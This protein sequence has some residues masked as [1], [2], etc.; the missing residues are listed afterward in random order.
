ML[1]VVSYDVATK[2]KEGP[3]RLRRIAKACENYGQRVQNSVFECVVDPDQ[4]TVL[5]LNL[6]DIFNPEKDSLRFYFVGTNYENRV[7]HHGA[8]PS[9]DV[10]GP[11]VV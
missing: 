3:R 10:K 8:K 4:W 2:E 1:V 5:K 11:L 7:E 6:L 9:V